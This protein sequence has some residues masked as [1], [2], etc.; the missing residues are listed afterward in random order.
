MPKCEN[1]YVTPCS[2]YL[3]P[4]GVVTV[5]FIDDGHI[6]RLKCNA[7]RVDLVRV[8]LVVYFVLVRWRRVDRLLSR[9]RRRC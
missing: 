6:V 7:T 2:V 5:V 8:N 3:V 1:S 4:D 9:R